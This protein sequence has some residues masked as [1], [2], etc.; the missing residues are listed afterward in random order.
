MNFSSI[1]LKVTELLP[2]LQDPLPLTL[3]DN[4]YS[5]MFDHCHF[6]FKGIQVKLNRYVMVLK[7]ELRMKT[8]I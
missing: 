2:L 5:I 6:Q 8:L 7:M 3:M 4:N 1:P